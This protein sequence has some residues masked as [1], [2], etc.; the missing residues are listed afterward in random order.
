MFICHYFHFC[1]HLFNHAQFLKCTSSIQCLSDMYMYTYSQ[2]I[3]I[4]KEEAP[5]MNWVQTKMKERNIF[6]GTWLDFHDWSFLKLLCISL[7][8]TCLPS[9][10]IFRFWCNFVVLLL[11]LAIVHIIKFVNYLFA[12]LCG[13]S[14]WQYGWKRWRIR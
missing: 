8:Q 13:V 7:K 12:F 10:P 9:P 14:H 2:Q 3:R 5:S 6:V 4:R 11:L 1:I